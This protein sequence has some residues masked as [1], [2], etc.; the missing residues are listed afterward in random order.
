MKIVWSQEL[1]HF[2]KNNNRFL[3]S[4]GRNPITYE[5]ALLRNNSSLLSEIQVKY[6]E[7]II[8][9]RDTAKL[10]MSRKK[11]IQ[12]ISYIGKAKL[13]VQADDHYDYLIWVKCLTSL[14]SIGR[15]VKGQ[16][17]TTEQSH[18]CVSQQYCWHMMIDAELEDLW[19]K[20]SPHDIFVRFY[21]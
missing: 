11:L 9:K 14:E 17:N 5:N 10:G 4:I 18:I 13:F 3:Q 21:H 20:N 12:F 2:L 6:V 15:M 7:D 19:Q 8:V 1:I 16:A